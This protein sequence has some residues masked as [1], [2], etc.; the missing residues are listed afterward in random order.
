LEGSLLAEV[1]IGS[2]G[3]AEEPMRGVVGVEVVMSVFMHSSDRVHSSRDDI[4]RGG[5]EDEL[6]LGKRL[7]R[8]SCQG[9][10]LEGRFDNWS[11]CFWV[12]YQ[13]F[14]II[15]K[16]EGSGCRVS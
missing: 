3:D 5:E 13:D 4:L 16:G 12:L 7:F 11:L 2:V 14:G 15:G 1:G 6:S 9:S 10:T 8:E